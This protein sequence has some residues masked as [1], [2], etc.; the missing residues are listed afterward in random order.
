MCDFL[1][2]R[3]V[4]SQVTCPPLQPCWLMPA[5]Y[6]TALAN[7]PT[8]QRQQP[9]ATQSDGPDGPDAQTQIKY[10]AKSCKQKNGVPN[11]EDMKLIA[12][13]IRMLGSVM[14]NASLQLIISL[15]CAYKVWSL[16]KVLYLNGLPHVSPLPTEPDLAPE[17]S[18][19]SSWDFSWD[20][21]REYL[22]GSFEFGMFGY[23]GFSFGHAYWAVHST[24]TAT[25]DWRLTAVKTLVFLLQDWARMPRR[26]NT[27]WFYLYMWFLIL[28][29]LYKFI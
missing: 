2:F 10:L 11:Y 18:W 16:C 20:S 7:R 1:D 23:V 6:Q 15:S 27:C 9:P 26:S 14:K 8:E 25:F 13:V 17:I 19:D 29:C 12:V 22:W 28:S 24:A 5:A 21:S 3:T 4:R